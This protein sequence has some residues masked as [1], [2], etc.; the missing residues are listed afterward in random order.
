MR[1][2]LTWLA[3]SVA[4]VLAFA[5][6]TARPTSGVRQAMLPI[7]NTA[8]AQNR[9]LAAAASS[10]VGKTLRYD[11]SY[12]QLDYPNGD[13][14]LDRGACTDVV[15]RALREMD[16]DLQREIH[17]D[18]RT[19]F[20][21]YPKLWGLTRPDRSIDH[22]RV[23]NVRTYLKRHG[24]SLPVTDDAV[25][26]QP[27]DIVTW[28]VLGADHVGVVSADRSPNGRRFL[29]THNIGAGAKQQDFLFAYPVTGHYR[30][31]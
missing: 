21:V 14:P 6:C 11:A 7:T 13:V 12:V 8:S 19:S 3:L 5:A 27:G 31:F 1:R 10:Q 16:V 25:D 9:E 23:P 26:Y 17:E 29:I 24:K 28:K 22:R 15:V 18:M 2:I 30:W 20:G 4:V